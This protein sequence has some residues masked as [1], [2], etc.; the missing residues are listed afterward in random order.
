MPT[1][2]NNP[3]RACARQP[4]LEDGTDC[5]DAQARLRLVPCVTASRIPVVKRWMRPPRPRRQFPNG[6]HPPR[7]GYATLP[8]SVD[9]SWFVALQSKL[10]GSIAPYPAALKAPFHSQI[11]EMAVGSA[12]DASGHHIVQCYAVPAEVETD[13]GLE[14][15]RRRLAAAMKQATPRRSTSSEIGP[16]KGDAAEETRHGQGR[17]ANETSSLSS[18]PVTRPRSSAVSDHAKRPPPGL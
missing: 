13:P 9:G 16:D 10:A 4:G 18:G 6:S 8:A 2:H 14:L 12:I 7:R 3:P 1:E 5:R 11:I 17:V 15:G